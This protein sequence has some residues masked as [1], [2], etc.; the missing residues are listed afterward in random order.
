MAVDRHATRS[1]Q[2]R[3]MT[4]GEFGTW[5]QD[6]I[7]N[8]ARSQARARDT[9]YEDEIDL[10]AESFERFL[11][12]GM[13]TA[14]SSLLIVLGSPDER[15]G[16][17][18]LGPHPTKPNATWVYEVV[19]DEAHRGKGHGRAAML[20]AERIAREAGHTAIGLNVFGFNQTA[21]SLYDSLGY[22]VS[23]VQMHK[24]L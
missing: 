3:P 6:A 19:I 17:L 23:S 12:D 18:W 13:A 14:G 21:R 22:E 15:V 20:A 8:Y 2:V 4:A 1:A 7:E 10:A 24:Q 16:V 9:A 5:R 11:P